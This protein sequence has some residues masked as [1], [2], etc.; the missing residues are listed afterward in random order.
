MFTKAVFAKVQIFGQTGLYALAW[1][2]TPNYNNSWGYWTMA[3]KNPN[4]IVDEITGKREIA[5]IIIL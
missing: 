1:F 3:N 4:V 2:D 5:S